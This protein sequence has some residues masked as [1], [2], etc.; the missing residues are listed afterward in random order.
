MHVKLSVVVPAFNEEKLLGATLDSIRDSGKVFTAAGWEWEI[1]VC[2]NNSTDRTAEIA[3]AAGAR[4]V[5]EPVNQIGRARNTG[6]AA[7]RGEWILFVDADSNPS[8]ELLHDVVGAVGSG[9]VLAGGSTLRMESPSRMVT[10]IASCWNR[11]SRFRRL[12]AGSFIFVNAAAF[13]EIG[14]FS[15]EFYASEEID[16]SRKLKRL[17]KSRRLEIRILHEHPLLTS[18][19]KLHLYGRREH[20][21][22]LLRTMLSGGRNLKKREGCPTWYD[23]RR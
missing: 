13:R 18:D 6:A 21:R 10:F 15:N 7:A 14:G 1:V 22:M 4:V 9:D 19:R 17:A 2:D 3:R 20:F 11:V 5:F 12:V 8:P 23:G 16:L